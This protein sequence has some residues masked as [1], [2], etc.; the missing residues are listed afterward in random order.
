VAGRM[1]GIASEILGLSG[2]SFT[3]MVTKRVNSVCQVFGHEAGET[4]GFS[5]SI[6]CLKEGKTI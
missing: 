4:L 5:S 6:C 2:S 3:L 1:R